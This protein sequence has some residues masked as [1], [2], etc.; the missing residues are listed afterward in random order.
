M[1]VFLNRRMVMGLNFRKS[2]KLLPGVK[3]NLSKG[4]VSLSGGVKGLRASIN[5]KGQV[6]G[7]AGIPGT[8]VYYT[9]K[10]TLPIGKNKKDKEKAKNTNTGMPGASTAP[11]S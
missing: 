9:K 4:G 6:T 7:T 5:T 11:G 10:K 3:L 1:I 2:I 8:G